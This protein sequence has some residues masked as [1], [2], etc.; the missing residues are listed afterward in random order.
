MFRLVQPA[1]RSKRE[2][3]WVAVA[4]RKEV[5]ADAANLRV[6]RRYRA[7]EIDTQDLA[8]ILRP[9]LRAH[10]G[11]GRQILGVVGVAA[12]RA[13]VA[14]LIADGE[15]QLPIGSKGKAAADVI[16]VRRQTRE[17]VDRLDQCASALVVP[18]PPDRHAPRKRRPRS[19]VVGEDH[20]D[21]V[22]AGATK[23]V[24]VK[25]QA[26]QAILRDALMDLRDADGNASRA[27]RRV[28]ANNA[29]PLALGDPQLL[30]RPPGDLPRSFESRSQDA[31]RE[32]LGRVGDDGRIL[33]RSH[34]GHGRDQSAE[35]SGRRFHK[36]Y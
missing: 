4:V 6:V 19:I 26:E 22:V 7:I 28:H 33:H 24:R 27:V 9:V 25:R 21:E 34:C 14:P 31:H 20:V 5:T 30:V 2:A 18:V 11:R 8:L 3:E 23:Q 35:C 16:I 17:D 15:I 36:R 13:E 32:A 1:V 10:V 29:P 12:I